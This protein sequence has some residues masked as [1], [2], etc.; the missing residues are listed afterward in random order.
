[1]VSDRKFSLHLPLATDNW[2]SCTAPT[3]HV[4]L[5]GMKRVYLWTALYFLPLFYLQSEL[6]YSLFGLHCSF[7]PCTHCGELCSHIPCSLFSSPCFLTLFTVSFCSF[8]VSHALW[9]H[10]YK[11]RGL[12]TYSL[13]FLLSLIEFLV[14]CEPLDLLPSSSTLRHA[15]TPSPSGSSV[16]HFPSACLDQCL[17]HRHRRSQSLG[18]N[19]LW[20]TTPFSFGVPSLARW[21]AS[22]PDSSTTQAQLHLLQDLI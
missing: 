6:S 22:D 18:H 7:L 14:P 9:A 21:S 5:F 10:V 16:Q 1:M 12:G 3:L 17:S 8:T 13:S 19:L 2:D 20:I 15:I 11:L 4:P